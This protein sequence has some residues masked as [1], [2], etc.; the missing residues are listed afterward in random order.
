VDI[1]LDDVDKNGV[2]LGRIYYA[3]STSA[4][5][6][7]DHSATTSTVWRASASPSST[8]TSP[9]ALALVTAGLARVDRY[10]ADRDSANAEVAALLL[11]QAVAKEEK[12]QL[13]S[14]YVEE[15]VKEEEQE[16]DEETT[17][18]LVS[19]IY[20]EIWRATRPYIARQSQSTQPAHVCCFIEYK[21]NYS[22]MTSCQYCES[23]LHCTIHYH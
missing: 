21:L 16:E 13:W 14:V 1:T 15:E 4:T 12:R 6:S 11:A 19:D 23:A 7:G 17:G 20:S 10:T 18:E 8:H 5:T 3:P 2:A 9:F 22:L